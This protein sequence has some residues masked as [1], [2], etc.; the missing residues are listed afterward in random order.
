VL[1]ILVLALC[2]SLRGAS[3]AVMVVLFV[4]LIAPSFTY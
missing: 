4:D 3:E 1:S 2:S